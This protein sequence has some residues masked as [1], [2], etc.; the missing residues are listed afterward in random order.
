M[1]GPTY[2]EARADLDRALARLRGQVARL[3]DPAAPRTHRSERTTPRHPRADVLLV[4]DDPFARE[5]GSMLREQLQGASVRVVQRAEDALDL[6]QRGTWR[7][8]VLDLHL[9][10][11]RITG[12][13]VLAALPAST[14]VVLV[15]GVE[16]R[17]LPQIA[18]EARV[19]AHLTKPFTPDVL[20]RVVGPLLAAAP[21]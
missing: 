3:L 5:L 19:D 18:R 8:A 1:A 21:R 14:R 11:S 16:P 7:V 13:D 6:A 20:A 12:L 2:D 15:T 17:D 10:H 9:G 4:D